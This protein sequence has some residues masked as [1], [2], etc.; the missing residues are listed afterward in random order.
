[1][2]VTS[3]PK[4]ECTA[5]PFP[6][7]TLKDLVEDFPKGFPRVACF[8]DSDDAFMVFRRFGIVF[9]RLLL[10][11]QDEIRQMEAELL[12]MDRTDDVT[13]GAPYLMSRTE[14]LQRDP[15][16]IPNAWSTTRPRLLESLETKVLEYC[17]TPSPY[18]RS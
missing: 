13:G 6:L 18:P 2:G 11:K 9:A 15:E 16:S 3:V 17:E 8:L 1:M 5:L 10:N 4:R 14:D 12:A 7:N